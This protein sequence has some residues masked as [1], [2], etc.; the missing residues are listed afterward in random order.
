MCSFDFCIFSKLWT[1]K[2]PAPTKIAGATDEQVKR[3][4]ELE[5]ALAKT[6]FVG[7]NALTHHDKTAWEA[8]K[9]CL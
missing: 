8:L 6:T 9:S 3:M 4:N 7:G 5:I 2:A 1:R